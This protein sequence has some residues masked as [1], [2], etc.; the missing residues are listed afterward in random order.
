MAEVQKIVKAF[1][2]YKKN[3][4]KFVPDKNWKRMV[5]NKMR[6]QGDTDNK[7]RLIRIN[8]KK[9]ASKTSILDTIV[10]EELHAQDMSKGEKKVYKKTAEIMER[11]TPKDKARLYARYKS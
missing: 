2:R 9:S 4:K 3:C 10:H 8:K 7:K 5:D 1:K 11:L 6:W